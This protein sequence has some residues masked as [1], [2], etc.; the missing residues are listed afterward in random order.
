[1]KQTYA[2]TTKLDEDSDAV[3]TQV[4]VDFDGFT[5]EQAIGHFFI[6]TSP[7]VALQARLRKTKGGIPGKLEVKALDL[8]G[9]GRTAA[10]RPMT[11]DEM[12]ASVK[13]GQMTPEQQAALREM[14]GQVNK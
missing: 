14:L 13:T 12:I 6:S 9:N 2:I 11:I 3:T 7:R 4:T 8:L 10:V 5:L 1:M